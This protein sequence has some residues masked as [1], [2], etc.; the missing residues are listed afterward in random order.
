VVLEHDQSQRMLATWQFNKARGVHATDLDAELI[1]ALIEQGMSEDAICEHLGVDL[2]TVHR[3][4]QLTGVAAI[5]QN[6]S[7]SLA[8]EMEK[9]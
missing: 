1:R 2:D 8:W 7:Y 9:V 5:F 3:Y 4:K 6:A